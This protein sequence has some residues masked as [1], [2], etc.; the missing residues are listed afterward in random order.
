VL[1]VYAMTKVNEQ[2]NAVTFLSSKAFGVEVPPPAY[3]SVGA[4]DV[5]LK[6][7]SHGAVVAQT[8][9]T[10][11]VEKAGVEEFVVKAAADYSL[12]Y[13]LA[14]MAMALMTGWLTL[15]AFRRD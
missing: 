2:S 5:D 4:D 7:F 1:P 12:A 6:L 9:L 8:S 15:V 3:V 10:F 13:G 11:A 14:T